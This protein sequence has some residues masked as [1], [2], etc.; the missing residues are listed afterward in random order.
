M[1]RTGRRVGATAIRQA[2]K[3]FG[4]TLL[5]GPRSLSATSDD[6]EVVGEAVLLQ[7]FGL[8]ADDSVAVYAVYGRGASAK[9]Q[10]FLL[11]G[12]ALVLTAQANAVLLA[13]SG[14]YRVVL[15]GTLGSKYV[16]YGRQTGGVET[17]DSPIPQPS[18]AHANR[19]NVFLSPDSTS[20]NS[21]TLEV[22]Q[23]PWHIMAF[24]LQSTDTVE[25][26]AS[27]QRDD[28]AHFEPYLFKGLSASLTADSNALVLDKQGVYQ[29]RLV[30]AL[31]TVTVVGNMTRYTS[32][33]TS[34][35]GGGSVDSV[36][37][38]V[39][40]TVN[41]ADPANPV[42]GLSSSSQANLGLAASALQTGD[43]IS[44]LVNDAGYARAY[45][46]IQASASDTWT[47]NH[48]LGF[49]PSV[50]PFTV[51]GAEFDATVQ[52]TS[53]NQTVVYLTIPLAG[54]ARLN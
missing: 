28:G 20:P 53:N 18:G 5:L 9:T 51:G 14:R 27:F 48:N 2:T 21:H 8:D 29:F 24:G 1:I 22:Y 46:H 23:H 35:G 19:P 7:A 45:T 38:G 41:T 25:V 34:G 12:N 4:Q 42:V 44:E 43:S 31:G 30:G 33:A 52:H 47:I 17:T 11:A 39:G 6:F 32:Q 40:I 54:S 36:L 49:K 13:T 50:E 16:I 3:A 37:A 26:W 10:P 15:T